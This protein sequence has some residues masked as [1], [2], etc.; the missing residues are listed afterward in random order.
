MTDEETIALLK[1]LLGEVLDADPGQYILGPDL[2]GRIRNAL[3]GNET[4]E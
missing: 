1:A 2:T 4:D 3:A